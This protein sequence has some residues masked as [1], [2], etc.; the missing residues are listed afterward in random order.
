ML[1][2]PR[3]WFCWTSRCCRCRGRCSCALCLAFSFSAARRADSLLEDA[4][5]QRAAECL[6]S[7]WRFAL[8]RQSRRR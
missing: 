7:L 5:L 3:G 8:E 6:I 4:C 2:F 1:A